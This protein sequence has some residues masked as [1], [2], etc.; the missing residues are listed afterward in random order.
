MLSV[1]DGAGN[2]RRG[3]PWTEIE[4]EAARAMRASGMTI[5]DVAIR[6]GRSRNAIVEKIV[7][8]RQWAPARRRAG[9]VP[10]AP[11]L[12]IVA[13]RDDRG[14]SLSAGIQIASQVPPPAPPA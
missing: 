6:M 4:V 7:P 11:R 13:Y 10:L 1:P 14:V 3:C 9:Y 12:G 2:S 5:D 8:L